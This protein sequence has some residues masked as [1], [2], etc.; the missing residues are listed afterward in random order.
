MSFTPVLASSDAT[1]SA[2]DGS[3]STGSLA[4]TNYLGTS[5]TVFTNSRRL[6]P[7]P[8]PSGSPSLQ[9]PA[10]DAGI[11]LM[12]LPSKS[13]LTTWART[14]LSTQGVP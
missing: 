13:G 2:Q 12:D 4:V 8:P 7:I 3:N 9:A 5:P 1:S 14:S 10:V 11:L 6:L